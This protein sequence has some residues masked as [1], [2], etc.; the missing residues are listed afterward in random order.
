MTITET[1]HGRVCSLPYQ[2]KSNL[3]EKWARSSDLKEI[4]RTTVRGVLVGQEISPACGFGYLLIKS[5]SVQLGLP[6]DPLV[7]GVSLI[8]LEL[9]SGLYAYAAFVEPDDPV[10]CHWVRAVLVA[11]PDT[12]DWMT[13]LYDNSLGLSCTLRD[14]NFDNWSTYATAYE[15]AIDRGCRA[16]CIVALQAPAA[17]EEVEEMELDTLDTYLEK[18]GPEDPMNR[19]LKTANN[20][21]NPPTELAL[22]EM[23][24]AKQLEVKL[25]KTGGKDKAW[26]WDRLAERISEGTKLGTLLHLEPTYI[27]PGE[28]I[29]YPEGM[30][31]PLLTTLI[32]QRKKTPQSFK[33][34]NTF[35]NGKD[36]SS[37]MPTDLTK[38]V[39]YH[40]LAW[41]E[42]AESQPVWSQQVMLNVDVNMT[43]YRKLFPASSSRLTAPHIDDLKNVDPE[44]KFIDYLISRVG[45]PPDYWSGEHDLWLTRLS[46]C[47]DIEETLRGPR[48]D[49]HWLPPDQQMDC[50]LNE[51]YRSL[52]DFNNTLE[53]LKSLPYHIQSLEDLPPT[54]LAGKMKVKW[55]VIVATY[56]TYL[57]RLALET[58]KQDAVTKSVKTYL[59]TGD[60][61]FSGFRHAGGDFLSDI[62]ADFH[63][64]LENHKGKVFLNKTERDLIPNLIKKVIKQVSKIS[65]GYLIKV[66]ETF[67]A[68]VI[69]TREKWAKHSKEIDRSVKPLNLITIDKTSV[70]ISEPSSFMFT[71][72]MRAYGQIEVMEQ[73]PGWLKNRGASKWC[74][75]DEIN[76]Y[77]KGCWKVTSYPVALEGF[78]L[79]SYGIM[80]ASVTGLSSTDDPPLLMSYALMDPGF[81]P[82]NHEVKCAL[83]EWICLGTHP[84]TTA[85]PPAKKL[86]EHFLQNE[87]MSMTQLANV[88]DPRFW[89]NVLEMI[90]EQIMPASAYRE[91]SGK[92]YALEIPLDMW[93]MPGY[94]EFPWRGGATSNDGHR[95]HE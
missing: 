20:F 31:I 84:T 77:N 38:I 63:E 24:K 45:S 66:G 62:S 2:V 86:Y 71:H 80:A 61:H 1:L 59:A 87:D 30:D 17:K 29:N 6:K 8:L 43:F 18:A 46:E 56:K 16:A 33:L 60:A 93:H 82:G 28:F 49:L 27:M 37:W 42:S 32:K 54:V 79:Q 88:H 26:L 14:H 75:T 9:N 95:H 72:L 74:F 69:D 39:D 67:M 51:C 85:T 81:L 19:A 65:K 50:N 22:W 34:A 23:I 55:E 73:I 3:S 53:K 11:Y 7:Y 64:T 12:T 21:D 68:T 47:L 94:D 70:E 41:K 58:K 92:L 48:Q 13:E 57:N 25:V 15:N 40:A 36:I 5:D 76:T 4:L 44:T 89:P 52:H 91:E 35:F 83:Y 90:V 10:L 78:V